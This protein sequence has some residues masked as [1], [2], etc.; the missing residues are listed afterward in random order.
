MYCPATSTGKSLMMHI[1]MLIF[2]G[3]E[4]P[5]S[6]T[7][8]E[9]TF[10]EMLEEGNI[11]GKC[12]GIISKNKI[13]LNSFWKKKSVYIT[14]F[15]KKL[16]LFLNTSYFVYQHFLHQQFHPYPHIAVKEFSTSKTASKNNIKPQFL[17]F[18]VK[19]TWERSEKRVRGKVYRPNGVMFIDANIIPSDLENHLPD[20]VLSKIHMNYTGPEPLNHPDEAEVV[21]RMLLNA[22]N[23]FKVNVFLTVV[24]PAPVSDS[25]LIITF[26]HWQTPTITLF[27][28]SDWVPLSIFGRLVAVQHLYSQLLF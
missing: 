10:F 3:S 8:T 15:I 20:A 28:S 5:T 24:R 21:D 25:V 27:D 2:G 13:I 6:T 14:I 16:S 1:N 7:M 26:S 23:M 18:A 4:Q 12:L 11:Y 22:K 17:L 19:S 9:A